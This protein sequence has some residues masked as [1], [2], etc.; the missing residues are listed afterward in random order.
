M[1]A[2]EERDRQPHLTTAMTYD[3]NSG[4]TSRTICSYSKH[5]KKNV[6]RIS[7]ARDPKLKH[8]ILDTKQFYTKL[9]ATE[10]SLPF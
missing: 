8:F 1:T 3:L 6:L 10:D 9:E 4:R 5:V 2:R 7:K